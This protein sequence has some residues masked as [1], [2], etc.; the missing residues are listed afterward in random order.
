[1]ERQRKRC[2]KIILLGDSGVGKT[3]I[4]QYF[5]KQKQV[6]MSTITKATIGADFC[7]KEIMVNNEIV[8]LQVWDTA[9]QERFQ[10]LSCAFYRGADACVLVYDTTNQTSFVN[11]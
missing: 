6:E 7:T 1:M 3:C 10:S 11:M 9:G 2:Y 8:S 5:K 4:I